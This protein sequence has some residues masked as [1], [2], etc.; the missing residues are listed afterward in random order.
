M[1]SPAAALLCLLQLCYDSCDSA[2]PP[3]AL[4]CLLRPCY[5]SAMCSKKSTMHQLKQ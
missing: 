5:V 1:R 2:M 4:L 3:A